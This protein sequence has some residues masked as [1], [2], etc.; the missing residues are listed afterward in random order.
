LFDD[1]DGKIEAILDVAMRVWRVVK[2]VVAH[3]AKIVKEWGIDLFPLGES[4]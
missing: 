1:K 4:R 3:G 2:K